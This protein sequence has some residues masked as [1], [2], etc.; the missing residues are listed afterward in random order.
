M[1]TVALT[2]DRIFNLELP[3]GHAAGRVA[4]RDYFDQAFPGFG[5]RVTSK[6]ARTWFLLKRL[7]G[8][9][10]RWT[11]GAAPRGRGLAGLSLAEARVVAV[12]YHAQ[13][14]AGIDPKAG[15]APAMAPGLCML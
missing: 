15:T 6:G 14:D 13:I 11:I 10:K 3:A 7:N 5:L 9:V 12:G 1:P 4:Q 8:R 2:Q